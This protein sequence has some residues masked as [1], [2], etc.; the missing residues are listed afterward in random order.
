MQR[1]CLA[2]VGCGDCDKML[3]TYHQLQPQFISLALLQ[4]PHILETFLV[5]PR[6]LHAYVLQHGVVLLLVFSSEVLVLW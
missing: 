5:L 2:R 1:Q 3:C 6:D 4:H